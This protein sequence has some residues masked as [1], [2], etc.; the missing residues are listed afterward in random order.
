MASNNTLARYELTRPEQ[1]KLIKKYLW[2]DRP[3][4]D[5]LLLETTVIYEPS[6][7]NGSHNQIEPKTSYVHE[8]PIHFQDAAEANEGAAQ[9]YERL[10]A[11]GWQ[12]YVGKPPVEIK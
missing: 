1:G 11:K 8:D 7:F 12:M 5:F 3:G 10:I 4:G 9:L 6:P 2:V